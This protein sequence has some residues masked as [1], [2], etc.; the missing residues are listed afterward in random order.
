MLGGDG[1]LPLRERVG[2]D[3]GDGEHRRG[4]HRDDRPQPPGP[5][6]LKA[7]AGG[8]RGDRGVDEL[9]RLLRQLG[10]P[11]RRAGPLP[12]DRELAAAPERRLLPVGLRPGFRAF[13]DPPP[14]PQALSVLDDP[15]AQP[16][17]GGEHGVVRELRA[18]GA[19]GDHPLVDEH[20]QDLV[21]VGVAGPVLGG[22]PQLGQRDRRAARRQVVAHVDKPEQQPPGEQPLRG[23]Q[24]LVGALRRLGQRVADP[25]ARP[26][27]GHGHRAAAAALPGGQHRVRQQRQRPGL[28]RLPLALA[29]V[30]MR[31]QV[32]ED[33]VHEAVLHLR[34]RLPG[35]LDDRPAHLL[36]VHRAEQDV[37]LLQRAQQPGVAHR[38]AV[39]VGAQRE[40]DEGFLRQGAQR[41]D[42]RAPS[43]LV[44]A[45]REDGLELVHDDRGG[46]RVLAPCG[47]CVCREAPG[48]V[49]L[50]TGRRLCAAG[51]IR[52][53]RGELRYPGHGQVVDR[54][55]VA[56]AR[57]LGFGG[58]PEP[59]QQP[60]PQ[61]GRLPR[62]GG[63]DE[64]QGQV[65]MLLR[66]ESDQLGD[67][68]AAEEQPLVG[69]LEPGQAPVRRPAAPPRCPPHPG[70]RPL[71]RL[72]PLRVFLAARPDDPGELLPVQRQVLTRKAIPRGR[73]RRPGRFRD[74]A[75]RQPGALAQRFQF[76]DE[77]PRRADRRQVLCLLLHRHIPIDTWIA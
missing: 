72:D 63:A 30:R 54:D 11:V 49:R 34:P 58:R 52:D 14:L 51:G 60:G 7:L 71:P 45:Q 59:G 21:G 62:P 35:G 42:Q 77:V 53:E 18:A 39:E 70:Q 46:A 36:G 6:P 9:N 57:R 48:A 73:Q 64:H 10:A 8:A 22:H 67:V 15:V 31:G 20:G 26:V 69:R 5:P 32:G 44:W 61:Q 40:H 24:A 75:D 3:A 76:A 74:L 38:L 55:L 66:E 25:A 12:G 50:G 37:P 43:G 19:H 65:R 23:G 27:V 1:V 4:Q 41:R 13:A 28:V 16:G 68:L 47:A 56:A 17:P 2:G 29:A 33:H